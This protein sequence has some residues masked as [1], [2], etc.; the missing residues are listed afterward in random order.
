MPALLLSQ[1]FADDLD[2]TDGAGS[3]S[4]PEQMAPSV[5]SSANPGTNSG[6]SGCWDINTEAAV[7][8]F[9]GVASTDRGATVVGGKE[10]AKVRLKKSNC[11]NWYAWSLPLLHAWKASQ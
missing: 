8:A 5:P 3:G 9:E 4:C 7:D 1:N 6:G 2:S 10:S 11:P